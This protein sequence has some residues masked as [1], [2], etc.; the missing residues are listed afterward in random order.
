MRKLPLLLLPIVIVNNLC[1]AQDTINPS[2]QFAIVHTTTD[3]KLKAA[4]FNTLGVYHFEKGSTDSA[5]HYKL[6]AVNLEKKIAAD[7]DT[8]FV[9][10]TG[11]D[12]LKITRLYMNMGLP[13]QAKQYAE[14]AR[15]FISKHPQLLGL[16]Y[17]NF[18]DI[19]RMYAQAGA[20]HISEAE[21]YYDSLT[22]FSKNSYPEAWTHRLA[23]DLAFTDYYL[24]LNNNDTALQ[25]IARA[26]ELA[27]KWADEVLLSQVTYMTAS[28]YLNQKD[29]ARALP[30]L[31]KIEPIAKEWSLDLYV[32]L[33]RDIARSSGAL[34][35]W[36]Q[37]YQYY[38]VYEPLRD[39]LYVHA[40]EKSFAEAEAKFQN[41]DKQLQ[42]E[43]KNLQLS[44]ARKQ[45]WWLIS[46]IGLL[47]LT[48]TL[49]VIIYRNKKKTA[50]ILDEKNKMLTSLNNALE[51]ANQTKAKLFSIISHDLRSPISQVYQFLKLQQLNPQLLD[52]KQK[53]ELSSKI[54]TATGSLLETM[55]DLLIWSKTQMSEFKTS[56]QTTA[57]LPVLKACQNLLH[58][59]SESK[60]ISYKM[61]LE[62]NDTVYTDPY[63]LQTI[64]RNLLQNAIK[65]SPQNGEIEIGTRN[66]QNDTILYI[67]N[68]GASFTQQDYLGMIANEENTKSLNGLGLML[69]EELSQKMGASVKF[70]GGTEGT[71]VELLIPAH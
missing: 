67:R 56:P 10:K 57:L 47:L 53:N 36:Q 38:S 15:P 66:Q 41:K 20:K 22:N 48:A 31:K 7:G 23:L 61:N 11:M 18:A 28:V 13:E 6:E 17:K 24:S 29:Y 43:T 2:A 40:T 3:N 32:N 46:G 49:L 69:V 33:L 58:L 9:R 44:V 30:Y 5:I 8:A 16:F 19:L 14:E 4:A 60:Q 34:G 55:E 50:D 70:I 71:L 51:D 21:L 64:I 54:Q 59:N 12:L 1:S 65:A 62:Q 27:P 25:Y 63:Y 42:I 39:T 68:Q 26:N 45:R 37:A 35:Q 52:E